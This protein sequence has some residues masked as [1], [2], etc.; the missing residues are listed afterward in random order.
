MDTGS[1][2]PLFQFR[3]VQCMVGMSG[4]YGRKGQ[5]AVKQ[6]LKGKPNPWRKKTWN[7]E[8]QFLMVVP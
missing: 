7:L 8:P 2:F 6:Y 3:S 5:L 4:R 1:H